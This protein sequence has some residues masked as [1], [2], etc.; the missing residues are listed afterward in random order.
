MNKASI[1]GPQRAY[2]EWYVRQLHL[3]KIYANTPRIQPDNRQLRRAEQRTL[4]TERLSLE[5][6]AARK[7]KRTKKSVES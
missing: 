6:K 2:G 1:S 3:D 5:K 4:S 7:A